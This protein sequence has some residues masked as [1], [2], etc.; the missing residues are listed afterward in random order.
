MLS[1]YLTLYSTLEI[2]PWN[3]IFLELVLL[4][5][6]LTENSSLSKTNLG[7]CQHMPISGES[8]DQLDPELSQQFLNDAEKVCHH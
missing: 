3:P 7:F 5:W 2:K 4:I 1:T 6:N 8:E